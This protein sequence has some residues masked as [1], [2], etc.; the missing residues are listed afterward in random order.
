V[1]SH[2]SLVVVNANASQMRDES[3][4]AA[5]VASIGAAL[6]RRDGVEPVIVETTARAETKPAVE[7]ALQRGARAVI[8][9]GGDGTLRDIASL[10]TDRGVPLGIVAAGTGNQLAAVLGLPLKAA[11]AAAALETAVTRVIDLGQVRVR[12]AD[13]TE[14]EEAFTI[15]CGVGFDAHLMATTPRHWKR[16]MGKAAYFLQAVTLAAGVDVVPYRFEVDGETF[17]TEASVALVGN[18]GQLVPGRL[19]LRLPLVPDD[20]L[21]DLI[22]V[23]AHGPIHGLKGLADQFLRTSL[24]G[25]AGSDSLRVRGRAI[26]VQAEPPQPLQ[27]DGDY[28]GEGALAATVLPGAL[29][30]LVPPG[31]ATRPA[32][33]GTPSVAGTATGP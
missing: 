15:G 29:R 27:V 12:L 18:I 2:A 17:E 22:V 24:G 5:V 25:G 21:L 20:G 4:R 9:V 26:A 10:L 19:D 6:R 13:G 16:R 32:A 11:L 3:A 8:G 30:V 33:S 1:R 7:A 23:G 14:I 31:V 28:L